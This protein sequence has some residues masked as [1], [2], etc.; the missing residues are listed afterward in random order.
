MPNPTLVKPSLIGS[1]VELVSATGRAVE[2][3]LGRIVALRVVDPVGTPAAP[4]A[5]AETIA[6][7]A[8][9]RGDAPHPAAD[10]GRWLFVHE[11][12]DATASAIPP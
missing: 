11:S 3:Q 5:L 4:A 1:V 7:D 10:V 2:G 9:N 8:L 6:L 12:H